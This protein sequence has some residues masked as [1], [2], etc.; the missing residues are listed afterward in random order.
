MFKVQSII[1]SFGEER[2]MVLH[3]KGEPVIPIMK[4]IKHKDSLGKAPNTLKTYCYHLK[5]FW[6]F[7]NE[8]NKDYREVDISLLTEFIHWLRKSTDDI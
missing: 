7:L 5:I 2:W 6:C 8:K 4:F 1:T 3:N